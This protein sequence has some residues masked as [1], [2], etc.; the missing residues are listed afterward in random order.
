MKH[1][2]LLALGLGSLSA[3]AALPAL[4]PIDTQEEFNTY[5]TIDANGDGKTWKFENHSAC[6]E[7]IG[8]S[9]A[10]DWLILGPVDL[11]DSSGSFSVTFEAWK[12][13]MPESYEVCVSTTGLPEDAIQI[14]STSDIPNSSAPVT[15]DFNIENPGEFYLMF[16]ANSPSNGI[17]LYVKNI[18]VNVNAPQGFTVPFNLIP[19]PEEAKYFTVVNSNEDSKTWT[20]DVTN[21][22]FS[23][24]CSSTEPS[25]DWLLLPEIEISEPGNYLFQW[26]AKV[27]GDPQSLDIYFGQGD[28]PTTFQPIF[29]E[30]EAKGGPY[31]R[32]VVINVNESGKYR[33]ALYS[34]TP[35]NH[36]KLLVRDFHLSS[37][38]KMPASDLPL[39]MSKQFTLS[40]DWSFSDPFLYNE[41]TRVKISA[42]IEGNAV[43]VGLANA[44][45]AEAV[46]NLF[47]FTE[48]EHSKILT[49]PGKGIGYLA[50]S[51]RDGA[52]LSNLKIEISN[53][54]NDA[55]ALPFSIQPTAEEFL[56]FKVVN[57]NGDASTWTYY[58][59][60]GAPRYNWSNTEKAD[61]WLILP[62]IDIPDSD[63][64][65]SFSFNARSMGPTFRETLEVWAG[66]T[67][68]IDEMQLLFESPEICTEQFSPYSFSFCPR[69]N[70]ITYFAVRATSEPKMFHL[71]VRDFEVK[72]DGRPTTIPS[73][74]KNLSATPAANG[75]TDANITFTLPT[76]NE[77]GHPLTQTELLTAEVITK[78]DSYETTGYPGQDINLTVN[79][80]QGEGTITVTVS[81]VYGVSNSVFVT[82][83]TGVDRPAQTNV[84]SVTADETNRKATITW[85]LSEIGATGG[86]VDLSN[87]S[88]TIKHAIGN[89]SY[90]NIGSVQGETEYTYSIPESYPLEMHYFIVTASNIAGEG[91]QGH[92]S[93]VMLGKPHSIPAVDDFS[94]GTINLG[95]IGM[96]NPDE[97]YTLDWYFDDP[98]LGFDEAANLSGHALIAFTEEYG[99]AR[100]RLN[101]SKFDTRTNNGARITIRVYN[102]PH[103]A[104]TDLWVEISDGTS[105]KIGEISPEEEAG[106]KEYSFPLPE[107][108][109][110]REWV[111]PYLDFGFDGSFD[112]E[113]WMMDRFGME[114]YYASEL[115]IRPVA[116]HPRMKVGE[117]YV[118][119]FQIGNFGQSEVE[120][121]HPIL[122]FTNSKGDVVSFPEIVFEV[123]TPIK[124]GE[125]QIWEYPVRLQTEMEGEIAYDITVMSYE[126]ENPDNNTLYGMVEVWQQEEFVVRDL[127]ITEGEEATM[128]EW[129]APS[130]GYGILYA[131]NLPS[132]EYG[133][134][135]GLFTNY[136]GDGMPI[137]GFVGQYF[138]GMG[139]PK[140]W[141]VFDYEEGGFNYIYSGYLGSAKS[142]IAFS[143]SPGYG[144]ADDWLISPEVKGGTELTF[145]VRP[146]HF[147]YGSETVEI[148]TSST[149]RNLSDFHLLSTYNTEVGE[150]DKTPYWEEVNATLPQNARFFAIR[151]V[152]NDIFGLQLDDILY[153]PAQEE[154]DEL[155]YSVIHNGQVIASGISELCYPIT[156]LG[157][158]QVAAEKAY[159]GLHPLSNQVTWW[160]GTSVSAVYDET[161]PSEFYDLGGRRISKP[162]EP[163]IYL[164]RKGSK[165]QKIIIR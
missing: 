58:D 10:D 47:T 155:T 44:P 85:E 100:G 130:T 142:L 134:D 90:Q 94:N 73:P 64:M 15:V 101:L 29:I 49:L 131:D 96:S 83:Y 143:P 56:D 57:L 48:S 22:G 140:A 98:A 164:I 103:F 121:P 114:N 108:L 46:T 92:G 139:Q 39:S 146:L 135:I 77:A 27:W 79:N 154:A 32:E 71:F 162:T 158:Y 3:S 18:Q 144:A 132:W 40:S 126:D 109:L 122:N 147:R 45:V 141:Q 93:G 36:Y 30:D 68:N 28:D 102:Y 50:F 70:G 91:E 113:I 78:E 151:Y 161:T 84:I 17:S 115:D 152:S 35:A 7:G 62:A 150:E 76:V 26:E 125:V 9:Y 87:V 6:Y 118:W 54:N 99:P 75:S 4:F 80:G 31:T 86:F 160:G 112:D 95:P 133:S 34:H 89:G 23:I 11:T 156:E 74:V 67:D 51:S 157:D 61:D 104:H 41:N 59:D 119:K 129:S 52:T 53:D 110:G 1:L 63:S 81:N 88:Y 111:A 12:T 38:D 117:Q 5:Q 25:D 69:W 55:Y 138:P 159:D 66:Q 124:P 165:T 149:S 106:W 137:T 43:T 82:V 116:I 37:T 72:A 8:T 33:L 13:F 21:N 42:E 60:F 19:Q 105:V 2:I 128:L 107:T 14:Y 24:E 136:D 145:Y 20:Y 153:T 120:I 97:R 16:H 148:L 163:G 65:I 123:M 127:H